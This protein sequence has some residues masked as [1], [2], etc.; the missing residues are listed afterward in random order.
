MSFTRRAVA[1]ARMVAHG[2]AISTTAATERHQ[3]EDAQRFLLDISAEF[4]SR[5]YETTLKRLAIRAV[6]FLADFCFFDVLSVDG[7]I[8]RVGWAHADAVKHELFDMVDEFVPALSSIDHPVSKVLRTGQSEFVPEV[9]DAWMRAAATS[10]RHFEL[11]R[12]LELRSMIAVPLL[13]AGWHAGCAHL[14]LLRELGTP[15]PSGGLMAGRGPRS[16]CRLGGGECPTLS[17]APG[18]GPP[19]G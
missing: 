10:Q 12:D 5:D 3:S 15:L 9:T 16:P 1:S 2:C 6:P 17:R 8:Q 19:Q 18:C 7:T 4:V 11:M 13:V 14:L